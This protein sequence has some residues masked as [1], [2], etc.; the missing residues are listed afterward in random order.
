[1]KLVLLTTL[2]YSS[3]A[4]S[5]NSRAPAV[6]DGTCDLNIPLTEEKVVNGKK[7]QVDRDIKEILKEQC[8]RVRQCMFS[9]EDEAMPDLK[10]L[11]AV[12][13]KNEYKGVSIE[14]PQLKKAVEEYNGGRI[15]KDFKVPVE[16]AKEGPA[17]SKTR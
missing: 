16:D 13:C 11:E 14:T 12:A 5:S 10:K 15:P 4:W 8:S 17:K 9:A 1:M 6:L 2:L 3:L 7:I